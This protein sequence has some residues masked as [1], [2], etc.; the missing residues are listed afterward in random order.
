MK[1][2]R[3]STKIPKLPNVA[4]LG[5]ALIGKHGWYVWSPHVRRQAI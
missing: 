1:R 2:D 3:I 5:E 4:L